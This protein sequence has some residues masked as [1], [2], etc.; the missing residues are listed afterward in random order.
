MA[1]QRFWILGRI[2]P[3]SEYKKADGE[4]DSPTDDC[5]LQELRTQLNFT[6]RPLCLNHTDRHEF[7][8]VTK[9]FIDVDGAKYIMGYVNLDEPLGRYARSLIRNKKWYDLSFKHGA[10]V[11]ANRRGDIT[12][13]EK[14]PVEVSLVEKARRDDDSCRVIHCYDDDELDALTAEIAKKHNILIPRTTIG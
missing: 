5:T 3:N 6:G 8:K 9:D 12:R 4:A 11:F 2:H 13:I 10:R 7:G 14:D 1:K